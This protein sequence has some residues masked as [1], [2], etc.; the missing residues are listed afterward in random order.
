MTDTLK[1]FSEKEKN[2]V[3]YM[4]EI[5]EKKVTELTKLLIS[6]CQEYDNILLPDVA[7]W[8]KENQEEKYSEVDERI[9]TMI[10]NIMVFYQEHEDEIFELAKEMLEE[11]KNHIT[12]I[13]TA[14][15]NYN[16][17]RKK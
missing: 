1:N 16:S 17:W 10:M 11:V 9:L 14:D 3:N 7:K 4:L 13:N 6:V 15:E 2:D 12:D 5:T 8:W